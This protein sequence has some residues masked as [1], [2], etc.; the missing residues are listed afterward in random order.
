MVNNLHQYFVCTMTCFNQTLLN[1]KDDKHE[2]RLKTRTN[3]FLVK[4]SYQ[5]LPSVYLRSNRANSE[6]TVRPITSS[7]MLGFT[8]LRAPSVGEERVCRFKK[9]LKIPNM[10]FSFCKVKKYIFVCDVSS[11]HPNAI[12]VTPF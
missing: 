9:T 5:C 6:Q 10:K 12:S 4:Y 11:H 3:F 7:I 8:V 1:V 2:P